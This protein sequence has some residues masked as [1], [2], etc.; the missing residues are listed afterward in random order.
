MVTNKSFHLKATMFIHSI[1][2]FHSLPSSRSLPLCTNVSFYHLQSTPRPWHCLHHAWLM[3]LRTVLASSHLSC[4]S[5]IFFCLIQKPQT[6]THLPTTHFS[7][8]SLSN[9]CALLPISIFSFYWS[10]WDMAFSLQFCHKVQHPGVAFSQLM[11]TL[12]FGRY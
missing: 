10:A 9:I 3:V 4:V 2:F 12:V 5:Q 8:L 6:W 11:L 7:S 1:V